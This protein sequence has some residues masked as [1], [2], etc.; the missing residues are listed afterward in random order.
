MNLKEVTY[1]KFHATVGQMDVHPK[2]VGSYPYTSE[3]R[4]RWGRER[5][6]VVDYHPN[7]HKGLVESKYF[8]VVGRQESLHD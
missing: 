3:F 8:V 6:R 2:V 1:E 5:G 4:D 7:G